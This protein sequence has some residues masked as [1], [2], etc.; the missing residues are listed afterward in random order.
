MTHSIGASTDS[1]HQDVERFAHRSHTHHFHAIGRI[2][3]SISVRNDTAPESKLSR[4]TK[5]ERSL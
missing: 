5:S 2:T 4:L 1:L 3:G